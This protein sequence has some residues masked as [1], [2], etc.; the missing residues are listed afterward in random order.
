MRFP[1]LAVLL[2][3]AP[4]VTWSAWFLWQAFRRWRFEHFCAMACGPFV[5]VELADHYRR[6]F[7]WQSPLLLAA[8]PLAALAAYWALRAVLK[9][10][11]A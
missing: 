2:V 5:P 8:L 3:A 7:D 6:A 4:A 10:W 9:R 1:R 11:P